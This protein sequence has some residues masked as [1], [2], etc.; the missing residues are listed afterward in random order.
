MIYIV[1]INNRVGRQ[2]HQCKGPEASTYMSKV[3]AKVSG[4]NGLA[5]VGHCHVLQVGGTT[6][7]V[8]GESK[9]WGRANTF[10][11]PCDVT[12][13]MLVGFTA[14][15]H[16]SAQCFRLWP[17]PQTG[18]RLTSWPSLLNG[19]ASWP[20]KRTQGRTSQGCVLS[21][22]NLYI[23]REGDYHVLTALCWVL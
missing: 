17:S 1:F 22:P 19:P 11:M 13:L 12:V 14:S 2:M 15:G 20:Q 8:G 7:G 21:S 10:Q 23:L 5:G 16:G 9:R 18:W 3:M 4:K 6:E